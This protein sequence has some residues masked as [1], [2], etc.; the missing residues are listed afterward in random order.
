MLLGRYGGLV[1]ATFTLV[2][3]S[4]MGDRG[5]TIRGAV[6]LAA[7]MTFTAVVLFSMVLGIQ[8]PLLVLG[9]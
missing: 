2:F 4:A 6:L 1:P 5:N 8:F 9:R 3:L 7:V